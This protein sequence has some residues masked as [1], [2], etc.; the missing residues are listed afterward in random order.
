MSTR[1]L[2]TEIFINRA[3]EIH[4]YKYDYS[5]VEYKNNRNK[6]TIICP[7]H[8]EFMLRPDIHIGNRCGGCPKCGIGTM[9]LKEFI[10]KA[11]IIHN[12]KY[13]YSNVDCVNNKTKVIITCSIHG[14]F[15]QTPSK[16]IIGQG[17]P[18]CNRSEI[19]G[20]KKMTNDEFIN[21]ANKIHQNR[22]TY[23]KTMYTY[24]KEK[25]WVTCPLHG[26]FNIT[27]DSHLRGS[28]CKKCGHNVSLSGDKWLDSFNNKNIERE[29]VIKIG[30]RKFKVDGID[31]T[32]N[33]IYEYFGSFW[34]GDP[35]KNGVH[36]ILNKTYK[37]LYDKTIDKINY[38]KSHG[39]NIIQKWG[40]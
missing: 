15:E 23:N 22:Y 40:K 26:D 10:D 13:D 6:I 20:S 3:V 33:T 8:G 7:N 38:I 25:V 29:V 35:T 19:C 24:A 34:H 12:N 32:T 17:C 37:E 18:F 1:R 14:D 21:N 30:D 16:H 39:F 28:G 36:P 9:G 31:Y 5:L 11:N 2:N 27:P 4:G